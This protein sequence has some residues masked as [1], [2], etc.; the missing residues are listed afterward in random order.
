LSEAFQL[1]RS[2]AAYEIEKIRTDVLNRLYF[3]EIEKIRV[4]KIF[5]KHGN[6]VKNNCFK[7]NKEFN[8]K[9]E[10]NNFEY[11]ESNNFENDFEE[12]DNYNAKIPKRERSPSASAFFS[13]SP[14][15]KI[16]LNFQEYLRYE[17]YTNG[18]SFRR[19][20]FRLKNKNQNF[21]KKNKRSREKPKIYS[22]SQESRLNT[23]KGVYCK[24]RNVSPKAT[25]NSL[26]NNLYPHSEYVEESSKC[27]MNEVKLNNVFTFKADRWDLLNRNNESN[28]R[29]SLESPTSNENFVNFKQL[30]K[31]KEN[32][33]PKKV[34]SK[35]KNKK[36]IYSEKEAIHKALKMIKNKFRKSQEEN[37]FDN[38]V[39][40]KFNSGEIDHLKNNDI[41]NKQKIY[42]GDNKFNNNISIK[43]QN[44]NNSEHAF[45]EESNTKLIRNNFNTE[46]NGISKTIAILLQ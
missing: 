24:D 11:Y 37:F 6:N 41:N 30:N 10:L 28:Q 16:P 15:A 19:F 21:S 23:S 22:R 20:D 9:K 38:K 5:N 3:N 46:F 33:S 13:G 27:D 26:N 17:F 34:I 2:Y 43:N 1:K 36:I 12:D 44:I 45:N 32:F 7:Y 39:K 4:K 25:F 42:L 18:G 31:S 35:N 8:R 14:V 40:E 29:I